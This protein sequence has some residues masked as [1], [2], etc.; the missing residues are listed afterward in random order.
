M[1]STID[2]DPAHEELPI[3]HAELL[4][5]IVA[6][7]TRLRRTVEN[8]IRFEEMASRLLSEINAINDRCSE[9]DKI[10]TDNWRDIV[11]IDNNVSTLNA[12]V[13]EGYDDLKAHCARIATLYHR[14]YRQDSFSAHYKQDQAPTGVQEKGGGRWVEDGLIHERIRTCLRTFFVPTFSVT[15]SLDGLCMFT[16]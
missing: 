10:C 2:S 1:A 13:E 12:R 8:Q 7:E 4:A 16:N 15:S 6:V 11:V 3:T 14:R 9:T 5:R